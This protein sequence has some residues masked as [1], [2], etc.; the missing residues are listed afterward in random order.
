VIILRVK[1]EHVL[2]AVSEEVDASAL[3]SAHIIL[4]YHRGW[5]IDGDIHPVT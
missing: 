4:G 2:A 5:L 1:A 3:S